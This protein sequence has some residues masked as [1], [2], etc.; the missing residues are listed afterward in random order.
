MGGPSP[1]PIV[2]PDLGGM[3]TG[4]F[5]VKAELPTPYRHPGSQVRE[6]TRCANVTITEPNE[7][8]LGFDTPVGRKGPFKP[9]TKRRS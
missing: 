4:K 7:H 6:A 2:Q 5:V 1:K 3:D 9:A 8:V